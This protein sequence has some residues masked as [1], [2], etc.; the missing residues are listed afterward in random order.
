MTDDELFQAAQNNKAEMG[1]YEKTEIRKAAV[2]AVM[3]CTIL[4]VVL[5]VVKFFANRIDFVEFIILC[6]IF[7]TLSFYEGKKFGNKNQIVK[8]VIATIFAIGFFV[9]F[10]GAM[11][12]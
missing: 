12:A 2:F 6:S 10:I 8:G 1:E 3:V 7:A 9:L 5:N 4:S 11:L